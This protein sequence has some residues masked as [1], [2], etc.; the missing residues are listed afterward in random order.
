M[1]DVVVR[2]SGLALVIS[3]SHGN[4]VLLEFYM[5]LIRGSNALRM[6]KSSRKID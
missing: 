2:L 1:N 5:C 3:E 6:S 4:A